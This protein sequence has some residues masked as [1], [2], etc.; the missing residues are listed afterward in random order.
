MSDTNTV[1]AARA[2]GTRGEPNRVVPL[3]RTSGHTWARQDGFRQVM[4]SFPTGVSVVTAKRGDGPRG[5]TCSSLMSI[6]LDP[7]TLAVCLNNTSST[8]RAV[9]E[10]G[11]FAVN[12]L[13]SGGER[14][15]RVFS[16]SVPDRFGMIR[17]SMS[18][19]GLPWLVEDAFAIAECRVTGMTAI[20]DHTMVFGE[21]TGTGQAPGSP[22]VYGHRL[23][24]SWDELGASDA[25]DVANTTL[26]HATAVARPA[27]IPFHREVSPDH[28]SAHR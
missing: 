23:F 7:P 6:C 25:V 12:L 13:H 20:G 22:L 28:D 10:Q 15:A 27:T 16:S 9:A 3:P 8:L 5:M 18:P 24:R 11:Q 2:P 21:V 17:W 1:R 4:G 26:G 19:S 14:A